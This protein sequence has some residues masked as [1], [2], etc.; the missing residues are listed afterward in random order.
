MDVMLERILSLIPH[1]ENGDYV[2]GEKKKFAARIGLKSGNLISDWEKGRSKS[3]EGYVYEIAQKYNVSVDW[4]KGESEQKEK[5]ATEVT[6]K[7]DRRSYAASFLEDATDEE[8]EKY[9]AFMEFNR[10]QRKGN[11]DEPANK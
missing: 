2:F 8:L 9:I 4:L 10:L 7:S 3:Y 11:E 6:G 1:K 5:P